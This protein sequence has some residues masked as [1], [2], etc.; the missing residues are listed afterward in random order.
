MLSHRL[1]SA[2]SSDQLTLPASDHGD[3]T[4]FLPNDDTPPPACSQRHETSRLTSATAVTVV[5]KWKF[6]LSNRPLL[7]M[8]QAICYMPA[9]SHQ[10]ANHQR[11]TCSRIC[12]GHRPVNVTQREYSSLVPRNKPGRSHSSTFIPVLS[13]RLGGGAPAAPLASI[14][15]VAVSRP[16][17]LQGLPVPPR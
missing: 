5:R 12:L 6:T 10:R 17:V 7:V 1:A 9:H 8:C 15:A 14:V 16:A 4:V 11:D 3:K 13:G 2:V